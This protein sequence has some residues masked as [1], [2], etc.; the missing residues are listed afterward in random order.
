MRSPVPCNGC[1]LCCTNGDAIILRADLG[2]DVESY[3]HEPGRHPFTGEPTVQL[4]HKPNGDCVYLGEGGCTIHD[5]APLI[6]R[7]FDCRTLYQKY[8]RKERRR[9]VAS[10]ATMQAV[11]DAG[12]ERL[13]SLT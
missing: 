2:D 10:G 7:R 11:L 3:E 12:R 8:S 5:R 6:C 13:G 1:T 9:L 4:K